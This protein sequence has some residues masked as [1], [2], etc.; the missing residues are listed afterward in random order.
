[1]H[2]SICNL[3]EGEQ[4]PSCPQSRN[5]YFPK[6]FPLQLSQKNINKQKQRQKHYYDW[7]AQTLQP[8]EIGEKVLFQNGRFWSK[9]TVTGKDNDPDPMS[10]T[11]QVAYTDETDGI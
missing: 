9:A 4:K 2:L 7:C 11:H 6:L 1:M 5:V 10:S 8:L 3:W